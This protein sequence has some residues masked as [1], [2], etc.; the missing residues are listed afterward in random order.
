MTPSDLPEDV[1]QL[2]RAAIPTID[3]LEVLVFLAQRPERA[4]PVA[5]IVAA[6]EHAGVTDRRARESLAELGAAGMVAAEAHAY[7]LVPPQGALETALRDLVRAYRERPVTLI[8]T[9]YTIA[10]HERI[11]SFADAFRLKK[12]DAP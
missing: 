2:I 9:V 7:R 1:R 12:K 3:A 11:Q 5:E 10:E 8:R 6:C 4:W